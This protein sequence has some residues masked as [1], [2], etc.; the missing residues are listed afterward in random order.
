MSMIKLL[1][2]PILAA[3]PGIAAAQDVHV[4]IA[5]LNLATPEGV[6]ALDRRIAE[7]VAIVCPDPGATVDRA[8]VYA[9]HRCRLRKQAEA[10]GQ[11]DRL[12]AR[13]RAVQVIAAR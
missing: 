4:P 13:A 5:G 8:R 12:V 1:V 3:V 2:I 11:R 9:T 6:Q 7:A 10:S